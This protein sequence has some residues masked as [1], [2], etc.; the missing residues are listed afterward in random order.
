MEDLDV[1]ETWKRSS[2]RCSR[3]QEEDTR[4]WPWRRFRCSSSTPQQPDGRGGLP[5]D[6]N[7]GDLPAAAA[8]AQPTAAEIRGPGRGGDLVQQRPQQPTVAEEV[9][10]DQAVEETWCSSR[11]S[12][13]RWQ[14]DD[15]EDGRGG[16]LRSTA[17][18]DGRGGYGGRHVVE[19][20]VQQRAC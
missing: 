20:L 8:A 4:I 15:T 14:S 11:R 9:I 17:A 13:R 18:A 10:D 19:D 12:S 2:T 3:W 5:E 7:G 1:V 6:R 16:D